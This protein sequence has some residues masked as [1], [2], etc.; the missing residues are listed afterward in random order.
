MRSRPTVLNIFNTMQPEVTAV[1][2]FACLLA[3]SLAM[4]VIQSALWHVLEAE[5]SQA[6]CTYKQGSASNIISAVEVSASDLPPRDIS[7][8]GI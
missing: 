2:A 6:P 8:S 4:A 5:L 7:A 3:Y 1:C